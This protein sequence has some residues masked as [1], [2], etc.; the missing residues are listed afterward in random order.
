VQPDD[1][2]G[3]PERAALAAQCVVEVLDEPDVRADL[4]PCSVYDRE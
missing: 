3:D 4:G 1:R 2:L